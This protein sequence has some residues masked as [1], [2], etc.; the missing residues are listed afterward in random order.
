MA[1]KIINNSGFAGINVGEIEN[2]YAKMAIRGKIAAGFCSNN[3]GNIKDSVSFSKTSKKCQLTASNA[4]S[5]D[6]T[7]FVRQQN[8]KII[9]PDNEPADQKKLDEIDLVPNMEDWYRENSD[10]DTYEVINTKEELIAFRDGVNNFDPKYT[11]G[12]FCLGND[13]NLD[14]IKWTPVG[15]D[16][17]AFSGKF[18]GNGFQITNF[19]VKDKTI[20]NAG[21]FGV[22]K[23]A[24]VVNLT[25]KCSI[26]SG[27]FAGMMVGVN[28][29]G[30]FMNCIC[31]GK[32]AAGGYSAGFVGRNTGRCVDCFV[33]GVVRTPFSEYLWLILLLLAILLL[34]LGALL[35]WWLINSVKS[36][37]YEPMPIDP[38]IT[39]IDDTV[40][41]S[42]PNRSSYQVSAE[43]HADT[44][45]ST[46]AIHFKNP[47]GTNQ[48]AKLTL[49]TSTQKGSEIA[50]SQGVIPPGNG[51]E[52]MQLHA[53]PNGQVLGAGTYK[54]YLLMEQYSPDTSE[55]SVVQNQAELTLVIGG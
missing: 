46:V 30:T 8:N 50:E 1:K 29:G 34:I 35:A 5:I 45:L 24:H 19:I 38:T 55:K 9:G 12:N 47:N 22:V 10:I 39:K 27:A 14:G 2:C 36:P 13:I 16:I 23:D 3:T 54:V 51:V 7:Y 40:D 15:N 33:S 37:P 21:F 53:L 42:G 25:I 17:S 41:L 18:D 31:Y 26:K 11:K 48:S 6:E 44:G 4:G 52:I 49:R 20:Q 43:I 32:V 28:D